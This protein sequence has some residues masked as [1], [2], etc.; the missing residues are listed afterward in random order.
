[1]SDTGGP[2]GQGGGLKGR[3]FEWVTHFYDAM[4][5]GMEQIY[6]D[7]N[8]PPPPSR[9]DAMLTR[10]TTPRPANLTAPPGARDDERTAIDS[11][12]AGLLAMVRGLVDREDTTEPEAAE[13]LLAQQVQDTRTRIAAEAQALAKRATDLTGRLNAL[14]VPPGATTEEGLALTGEAARILSTV[15]A[16]PT[17]AA[18]DR[19][20]T[21]ERTLAQRVQAVAQA[22]EQR[23]IAAEARAKRATDLGLRL[24]KIAPAPGAT[25]AE[26]KAITDRAAALAA[27][28]DPLTD[29][30]LDDAEAG[31]DKLAADAEALKLTVA[32]RAKRAVDLTGRL[33]GIGAPPGAT[34]DEAKA[35]TDRAAALSALP[36]P[37]T[38]KALD[39][40]EAGADKLDA[41]VAQLALTVADRRKRADAAVLKAKAVTIPPGATVAEGKALTD[42]AAEIEAALPA[43]LTHGAV[44]QAEDDAA[45]LVA[46]RQVLVNAIEARRVR[47]EALVKDLTDAKGKVPAD[48]NDTEKADLEKLCDDGIAALIAPVTPEMLVTGDKAKADA[49]ARLIEIDAAIAARAVLRKGMT[50][51]LAL[52]PTPLATASEMRALA[53]R[54]A[55]LVKEIADAKDKKALDDAEAKVKEVEKD[56]PELALLYAALAKGR[57]SLAAAKA[58][59]REAMPRLEQGFN[60]YL[61]K[62]IDI[63]G[64][65]I[66]AA[67]AP[68]T[69]TAQEKVLT[70][71]LALLAQA[72][73]FADRLV[74]WRIKTDVY[75]AAGVSAADKADVTKA[76]DEQYKAAQAAAGQGNFVAADKALTDFDTK[77]KVD[78]TKVGEA[79]AWQGVLKAFH[80]K[81]DAG[82]EL[83]YDT[84]ID[85]TTSMAK[86]FKA[87]LD[88]IPAATAKATK[89]QDYAAAGLDLAAVEP[90]LD[91]IIASANLIKRFA[92]LSLASK[93]V[94]NASGDEY[95][96]AVALLK[97][98]NAA[99]GLA[100][101]KKV[102]VRDG[103]TA[104]AKR[105]MTSLGSKADGLFAG[106]A[107][108]FKSYVRA[109]V[110]AADGKITANDLAQAKTHLDE[111]ETRLGLARPWVGPF[112]AAEARRKAVD[113]GDAFQILKPARDDMT[114]GNPGA[115]LAKINAALPKLVELETYKALKEQVDKLKASLTAPSPAFAL[116]DK[117]LTDADAKYGAKDATA[118]VALLQKVIAD[119]AVDALAADV[120]LWQK[121][122]A[123][124]TKRTD[125]V[126]KTFDLPEAKVALEASL[127]VA[128]D[129]GDAGN[130]PTEGLA[131]LDDHDT[132]MAEAQPCAVI[133]QRVLAIRAALVKAAAN[134]TD[135]TDK[136]SVYEGTSAAAIQKDV[137][138]AIAD[139]KAGKFAAA[140]AA[141]KQVLTT[142]Q[143]AIRNTAKVYEKLDGVDSN[144]G[145]SLLRH[146]PD[147]TDADLLKRLL[148]GKDPVGDTSYCPSSSKF[149]SPEAWLAGRQKAEEEA[150][151]AGIDVSLTTLP[152]TAVIRKQVIIDH[153]GPIDKAFDGVKEA[154]GVS[155]EGDIKALGNYET[156]EEMS[157]ITKSITLFLFELASP[158]TNATRPKDVKEYKER[159][160]AAHANADAPDLRGRWVMMQHFPL[161]KGW[162]Q[163]KQD[164]V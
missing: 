18:L 115:S 13:A 96:A 112:N 37:L 106:D 30:A 22:V 89:N 82:I 156:Y 5:W 10:L 58:A 121:R 64:K 110:T 32:A 9:A 88:L 109:E 125:K 62:L 24:G 154:L 161:V 31:A 52:V 59:H 76:R 80:A 69:V 159:Y 2:E 25:A 132:L 86:Q 33:K 39:D 141:F 152:V 83:L 7:P 116:V 43:P 151:A 56:F 118:A 66:E 51:R 160:K 123:A 92:A 8:E 35:I 163:E 63:A 15:P 29:K 133:Y 134:F 93:P 26:A 1:M 158:D 16:N 46:R 41:D 45:D 119:P 84:K 108:T 147:T 12:Y 60:G 14:A 140:T 138:D 17:A 50:D 153:G 57:E 135:P 149:E 53:K 145:H 130:K 61:G 136:A 97:T 101:L 162:N 103:A 128:T 114:A 150:L 117:A 81:Y 85:S 11:A 36:D 54:R 95:K 157:G 73:A 67:K 21:D 34:G 27:L 65:A 55:D 98:G 155:D 104:E 94:G 100:E 48:A 137:D 23:R 70:D 142:C 143:K 44:K 111:A 107:S 144:A 105:R 74:Q 120:T 79:A 75:I 42:R 6:P 148:T 68:A 3:L 71:A 47:G 91:D 113:P 90:Q 4:A 129:L 77:P 164:Y 49:D 78:G 28:P 124:A 122:S 131:K 72:E 40:A 87:V 102:D 139:V 99:G 38:D 146:G 20:E 19:A 126:V 127:K